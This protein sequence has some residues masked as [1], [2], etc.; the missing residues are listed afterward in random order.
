MYWSLELTRAE[1]QAEL[2]YLEPDKIRSAGAQA[3]QE[4][5]ESD[6]PR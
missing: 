1:R 6:K 5:L 2:K 4:E 3:V